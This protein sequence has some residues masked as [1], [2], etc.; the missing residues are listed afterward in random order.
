MV[1]I[2]RQAAFAGNFRDPR[3]PFNQPGP[4]SGESINLGI[5]YKDLTATDLIGMMIQ[6][7][8]EG[9]TFPK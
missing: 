9:V 8:H 5:S 2:W 1:A 6:N 7:F 3:D 4:Q